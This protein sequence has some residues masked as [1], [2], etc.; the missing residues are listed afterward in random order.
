MFVQGMVLPD[1]RLDIIDLATGAVVTRGYF[2]AKQEEQIGD[3]IRN[4]DPI[5]MS[6]KLYGILHDYDDKT[7]FGHWLANNTSLPFDPGL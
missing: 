4:L 1:Y 2:T 3:I 5:A 6:F 7:D